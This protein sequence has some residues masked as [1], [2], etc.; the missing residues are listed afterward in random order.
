[1]LIIIIA[2]IYIVLIIVLTYINLFNSQITQ[3]GKILYM[4]IL[5]SD[6]EPETQNYLTCLKVCC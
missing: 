2:D 3:W 1:M 6:K 5:E 4:L